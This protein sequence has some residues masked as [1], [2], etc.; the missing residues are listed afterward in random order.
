MGHSMRAMAQS[1]LDLSDRLLR[2]E[3]SVRDI[4]PFA[5]AG[6]LEEVVEGVEFLPSFA[7]VSASSTDEGL[8]LVDTGSQA[9]PKR[10]HDQ[11][12][13]WSD[14]PLHTAVYSHGH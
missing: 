11:I 9:Q 2:G 12:R 10:V 6:D 14:L 5:A 13:R 8:C 4:R 3:A 7:N 1:V